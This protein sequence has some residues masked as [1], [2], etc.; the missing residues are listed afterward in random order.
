MTDTLVNSLEFQVTTITVNS[1]ISE[2]K[3]ESDDPEE[4]IS[5]TLPE[6]YSRFIE[7]KQ[8]LHR[9]LCSYL[10]FEQV[11]SNKALMISESHSYSL[12]KL[13]QTRM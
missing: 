5:S 11:S 3:S 9:N 4:N 12:D 8:V 13:L 6:I 10:S 2:T 1:N 7:A